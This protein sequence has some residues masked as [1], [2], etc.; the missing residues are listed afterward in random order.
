[1][2]CLGLT[3]MALAIWFTPPNHRFW[4]SHTGRIICA[5]PGCTRTDGTLRDETSDRRNSDNRPPAIVIHDPRPARQPW[6]NN[7]RTDR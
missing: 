7:P 1:M 3:A 2:V 5:A 4:Q 6:T